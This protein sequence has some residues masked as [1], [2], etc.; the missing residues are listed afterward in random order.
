MS[1]AG[2]ELDGGDVVFNIRFMVFLILRRTAHAVFLIHPSDHSNGAFGPQTQLLQR[3]RNLHGSRNTRTV[4]D[5]AS[6]QAPGVEM[7]GEDDYLLGMLTP[8]NV[9]N[10][11]CTFGVRQ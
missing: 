7:A 3:L 9:C 1:S 10:N 5:C 4:I 2:V 11:V 8:L 6:S